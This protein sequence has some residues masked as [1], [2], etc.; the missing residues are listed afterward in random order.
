MPHRHATQHTR[1]QA[2]QQQEEHKTSA[3]NLLKRWPGPHTEAGQAT[4]APPAGVQHGKQAG[5]SA[6]DD[7][8]RAAP[9]RARTEQAPRAGGRARQQL[10]PQ[11]AR[12]AKP[13]R[14]HPATAAQTPGQ[15]TTA[16][17][18]G[19]PAGS[20][21]LGSSDEC[22][23]RG[24][25][26]GFPAGA[27]SVRRSL[28]LWSGLA[29][30]SFL[31]LPPPGAQARSWQCPRAPT[32]RAFCKTIGRGARSA[33]QSGR[34]CALGR[35]NAPTDRDDAGSEPSSNFYSAPL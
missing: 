3:N 20:A 16:P 22:R 25:G 19:R 24:L 12:R 21:A 35:A 23:P 30:G 26:C 1:R 27:W 31:E 6:P 33:D 9:P 28:T 13:R 4:A 11:P 34:V 7:A 29:R 5:D 32:G 15:P 17:R 10:L 14:A 8:A 18:A 2:H